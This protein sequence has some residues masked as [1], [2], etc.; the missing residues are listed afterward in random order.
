MLRE[1]FQRLAFVVVAVACLQS[2]FAQTGSPATAAPTVAAPPLPALP[3]KP[4]DILNLGHQLNGLGDPTLPPWHARVSYQILDKT[5]ATKEQGTFEEF[6][7][8]PNQYKRIFTSPSFTQTEYQTAQGRYRKG[9]Q[10]RPPYPERLLDSVLLHPMTEAPKGSSFIPVMRQQKAGATE[11]QCVMIAPDIPGARGAP[12]SVYPTYC[13]SQDHP[14][15]RLAA[16]GV[17]QQILFNNVVLF[18]QHFIAEDAVVQIRGAVTLKM[19]LESLGTILNPDP[20]AFAPPADAVLA[21]PSAPSSAMQGHLISQARPIYPEA[22]KR[23]GISGVVILDG[24]ITTEGRVKDL[25]VATSPDQDLAFAALDAVRQWRYKPYLID[26][27]P[28]EVETD[29]TITFN[30]V[31]R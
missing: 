13:F 8:G 5:G 21:P 16:T 26:G 25:Q 30:Y 10:S 11:L 14:L 9:A 31:S 2:G 3:T 12:L 24:I 28:V 17:R 27:K 6:W 22:A 7:S 19:H 15:L 18:H 20:A 29:I 23:L 1:T 4:A